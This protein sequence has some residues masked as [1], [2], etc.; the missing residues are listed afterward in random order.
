MTG[1]TG[2]SSFRKFTLQAAIILSFLTGCAS[3]IDGIKRDIGKVTN[4]DEGTKQETVQ[5]EDKRICAKNF[6]V[7]GNFFSGK[8]YK[9]YQELS[10]VSESRAFKSVAQ[11]M[12]TQGWTVV[13]TDAELG[14]LTATRGAVGSNTAKTLPLNILVKEVG[15]GKVR[16]ETTFSTSFGL[17]TSADGQKDELCK[18]VE[19][20]SY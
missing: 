16:I 11:Y 15:G 6:T 3:T 19:A 1:H 18:I 13:N 5:V 9:S 10:G 7:T 2:T 12:A 20:A 17:V 8:Q 14:V 4:S